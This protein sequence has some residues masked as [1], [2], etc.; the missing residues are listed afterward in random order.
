MEFGVSFVKK[1]QLKLSTLIILFVCTVVL[2][3]LLLTDLLIT[4]TI[5]ENIESSIEEKAKVVARTVAHSTIVK[6]GLGN[7]DNEEEIQD[8]TLDI[9]KSAEVLFVVVMDMNGIRKSHPNQEQI[10]KHFVGGDE[11]EVLRGKESLSISEGTLGKSVRAFSPVYNDNNQQIGAVAVGISLNR[12]EE[13]LNQSHKNILT[14]SIIGIIVGIIG[15][16][17][18][19][20]YIKKILFGLEPGS[21]AKILEERNTMLQSVHEGVVAVNEDTTISLVNKSALRIFT[22][23]GLD[24]NPVG[25][26]IKEFMPSSR[27]EMVM[28]TGKP[29]LDEEQ[30]INGVSILE[31]RVPLIV[32]EEVVGAISTFRDKTDVNRLAEQLT[33]VKSYAEAL[34]AQSHEFMNKMHVILGLVKMKDYSRLNQYIKELVSINIDEV[35]TISS[36]IKD[37][38][39]AGFIMGKLSHAREKGVELTVD[40]QNAIP[41]PM[42]PE[43]T[44]HLI[45]IIGNLV[46][47]SIEA[48]AECI[49]REVLL[50]LNYENTALEL[51]V[52]DSGHGIPED[53]MDDIFQKGYSSKGAGR[54]Y[55]LFLVIESLNELDGHL[56]VES[57]EK[58]GT[59]MIVQ[60]SFGGN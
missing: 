23:A 26:P 44:H 51:I 4:R 54:G 17:I 18:I 1:K 45:T 37:P 10:G 46:D 11:K 7:L 8:Y 49:E 2:V 24:V 5:N 39:L 12:V 28:K 32:N 14:G 56:N 21:I 42:N 43:V 15:A 6:D 50:E 59:T 22:K 13:A 29:E 40:C 55:G 3:S 52:T 36:N 60:A 57:K 33:G 25:Q 48:T 58:S 19:A 38:A 34:R 27:L 30:I 47:N 20:R 31:N 35:S 9:Q 53:I 16:F 41:E